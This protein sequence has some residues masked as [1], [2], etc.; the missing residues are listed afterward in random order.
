MRRGSIRISC[1]DVT[2]VNTN[3]ALLEHTY[4]IAIAI[5]GCVSE[6][7][8]IFGIAAHEILNNTILYRTVLEKK[9]HFFITL[10]H[11]ITQDV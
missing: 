4:I 8:I 6:T 7:L 10:D 1:C 9:P 2:D 11:K 3:C 5:L